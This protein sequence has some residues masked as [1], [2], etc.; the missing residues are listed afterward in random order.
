LQNDLVNDFGEMNLQ[1]PSRTLAGSALRNF[2]TSTSCPTTP[3]SL[4]G[5]YLTSVYQVIF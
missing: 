2:S 4:E 5:L 1:V 3:I